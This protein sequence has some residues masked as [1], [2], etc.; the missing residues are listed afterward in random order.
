M[1][2]TRSPLK[3]KPLRNAGQSLEEEITK[4]IEDGMFTYYLSVAIFIMLAVSEWIK[5]Y[6]QQP[7]SPIMLS[8]IAVLI[9][10]FSAYK[11]NKLAKKIKLLKQGRD[12]EKA[13]GQYLELF[14]E[15]G[16]KVFHDIVGDNFNIDHVLVSNKG[17]FLIE[18]KTYSKP[19]KGKSEI[20]FDGQSLSINGKI[21]NDNIIQVTAGALWLSNLIEELTARK[22][23][24]YPVILFPGWYVKMTNKFQ[25]NIWVLN[26]KSLNKFI[27]N[28]KEI[29]SSEDVKLVSNHIGRYIRSTEK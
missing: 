7:P 24:I 3:N 14:R 16:I 12:G 28:Q 17:I 11:I 18:T 21:Y 26:P 27:N 13:V 4:N 1:K 29:L 20:F 22:Y 6:F 25:S 15:Q 23:Q 10:I 2:K 5:W 8:I 19:L 9:T